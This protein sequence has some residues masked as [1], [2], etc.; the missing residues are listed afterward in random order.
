M[1]VFN[2]LLNITLCQHAFYDGLFCLINKK[3][4]SDPWPGA[5]C[6]VTTTSVIYCKKQRFFSNAVELCAQM[7]NT[8]TEICY[9]VFQAF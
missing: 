6:V 4:P 9:L 5:V 3:S 7:I 2:I 8:K 1:L